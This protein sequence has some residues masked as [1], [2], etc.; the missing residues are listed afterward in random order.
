MLKTK[1]LSQ[2]TVKVKMKLVQSSWKIIDTARGRL[3]IRFMEDYRYGSWKI[4]ST[5]RGKLLSIKY[6][7]NLGV[8]P[9]S[10][11]TIVKL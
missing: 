5:A 10:V 8:Q 1:K 9:H 7:F 4:I 3:S 6:S 11:Q 2:K